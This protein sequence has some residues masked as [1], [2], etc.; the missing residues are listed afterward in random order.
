ME[1]TLTLQKDAKPEQE[2]PVEVLESIHIDLAPGASQALNTGGRQ[3]VHGGT[4]MVPVNVAWFL[5]E[6]MA[7][8]WSHEASLKDRSDYSKN[9]VGRVGRNV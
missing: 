3:F 7:R 5:K 1:K 9:R 4:Y 2:T 8:G 6:Q